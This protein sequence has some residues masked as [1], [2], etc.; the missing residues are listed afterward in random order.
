MQK[1]DCW[2][3]SCGPPHWTH[4]ESLNLEPCSTWLGATD[5]PLCPVCTG[6]CPDKIKRAW[7][8]S[9]MHGNA[10]RQ[11]RVNGCVCMQAPMSVCICICTC[12]HSCAKRGSRWL[13]PS[14]KVLAKVWVTLLQGTGELPGLGSW[15]EWGEG[16]QS[17][18]KGNWCA[19]LYEDRNIIFFIKTILKLLASP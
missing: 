7:N 17:S 5:F 6:Q 1:D 14:S 13:S 19:V 10:S 18:G 3:E 9:G 11:G 12:T 8:G 4:F 16:E 15:G 2:L